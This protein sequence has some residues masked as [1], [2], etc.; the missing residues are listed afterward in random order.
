MSEQFKKQ[1]FDKELVLKITATAITLYL[2]EDHEQINEEKISKFVVK[3]FA[4]IVDS[5]TS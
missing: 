5:V 1:L 2:L 4:Q 3:N